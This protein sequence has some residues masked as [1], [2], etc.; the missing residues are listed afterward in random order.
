MEGRYF[1]AGRPQHRVAGVTE[2]RPS[3]QFPETLT[4]AGEVRDADDSGARPVRSTYHLEVSGANIVRFRMDSLPLG[5]VLTGD[6]YFDDEALVVRYAS[7]DRRIQGVETFVRRHDGEL[8]TSGV[9]LADGAPVTAW[10]AR[11]E[12]VGH[13]PRGSHD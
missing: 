3:D 12:K 6:G 1:P 7:P 11:L 5:T 10:L 8:R 9:L 2:V 4:V 13:D